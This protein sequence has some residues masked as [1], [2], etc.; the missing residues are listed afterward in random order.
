L[1]TEAAI[2][3]LVEAVPDPSLGLPDNVFYYIS[4]TTP[5][6]NVDLLIKDKNGRTLLSW[7]NDIY[8]GNGWHVPGGIVRFKEPLETRIEQVARVEIGA[9][10]TFDPTPIALHQMIHQEREI[11]GHFI[12]LLYKCY[13]PGTF[14]P[15]NER[16][17]IEDGGY[18]MWH[19]RC[20]ANLLSIHEIYR[21]Y[22][23]ETSRRKRS[24]L[25]Q[26]T[27]Y[28]PK[29]SDILSEGGVKGYA[30]R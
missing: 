6:I 28:I 18:L 21:E 20:P 13:L 8:S 25:K 12:S 9:A 5:L 4:R 1:N 14:K 29:N 2:A 15:K 16:I 3:A 27:V 30:N 17:T 19:D 24:M 10:V 7:R 26:R 11:R 23:N 22:I